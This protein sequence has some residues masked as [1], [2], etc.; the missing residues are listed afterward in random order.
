MF[1]DFFVRALIAGIG[2][3]IIA[4]PLGSFIVWRKM[5]YFGETISHAG[6]LGVALAILLNTSLLASIFAIGVAIS[7]SLIYLQNRHTLSN[8]TLL[9]ILSHSTLA[10]GLVIISFMTWVNIDINSYLFGSILTV[11]RQDIAIIYI[12]GAIIF[13]V[14]FKIWRSLLTTTISLDMAHT[15]G[16]KPLRSNIFFTLLIAGFVAIAMKVVGIIL[17]TS[18]LI[19]PAATARKFSSTPEGMAISASIFGVVA[20]IAGLFGSLKFDTPSGPSIILAAFGLFLL[21]PSPL[22]I[23]WRKAINKGQKQP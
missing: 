2:L 16:L 19:I 12:G 6:L 13:T 23:L 11:T 10:L 21:C 3:A 15:E 18:L 14:L 4:G 7:F 20:V 5:A 1:D 9:G 8:D 22:I 17:V